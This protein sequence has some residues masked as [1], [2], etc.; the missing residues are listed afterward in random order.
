[1]QRQAAF[2]HFD[3][4]QDGLLIAGE[5]IEVPMSDVSVAVAQVLFFF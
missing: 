4:D 5:I 1:M 3:S 2:D